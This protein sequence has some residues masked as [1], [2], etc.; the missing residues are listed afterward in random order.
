MLFFLWCLELVQL[1]RS[2]ICFCDNYMTLFIH[3]SK[4][5]CYREGNN[6][7][8]S[9]TDEIT[10]PVKMTRRCL[11]LAKINDQ[12]DQYFF[13]SVTY[14]TYCNN[15]NKYIVKGDKYLSISQKLE[16]FLPALT[17]L[18]YLKINPSLSYKAF[19]LAELLWRLIMVCVRSI[20]YKTQ[21]ME[22]RF[23]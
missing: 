9:W 13:R 18:G 19:A 3:N 20:I 6:V 14:Y 2:D 22:I 16:I 10:C 4:T 1:K 12:S 17:S 11:T 23:C 15:S 5:D 21:S 7:I 8:I